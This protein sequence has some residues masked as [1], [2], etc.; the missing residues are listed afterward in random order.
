MT[1][2]ALV[3]ALGIGHRLAMLMRCRARAAY[4]TADRLGQASKLKAPVP[5]HGIQEAAKSRKAHMILM[6]SH[7]RRGLSGVLIG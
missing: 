1:A 6:A 5:W 3:E 2:A 7:G 4:I